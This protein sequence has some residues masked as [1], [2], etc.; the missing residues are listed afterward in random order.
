MDSTVDLVWNVAEGN[1]GQRPL[2]F[3]FWLGTDFSRYDIQHSRQR[4]AGSSTEH[5]VSGSQSRDTRH[6][7]RLLSVQISLSPFHTRL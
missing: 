4:G 6:D 5:D 2:L 1:H 7:L 3:L